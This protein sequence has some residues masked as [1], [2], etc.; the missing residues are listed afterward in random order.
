VNSAQVSDPEG[1][2]ARL[3]YLLNNFLAAQEDGGELEGFGE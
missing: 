1:K 2:A 3:T